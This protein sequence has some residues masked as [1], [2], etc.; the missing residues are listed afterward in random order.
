MSRFKPPE[1]TGLKDV[2]K[3]LQRFVPMVGRE[4][5]NIKKSIPAKGPTVAEIIAAAA[6]SPELKD[7]IYRYIKD[8]EARET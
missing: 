3:Y 8:R 1:M 7:A 4:L 2:I 5:E 6:E